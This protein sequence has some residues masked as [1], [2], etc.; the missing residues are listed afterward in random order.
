M[1]FT[2]GDRWFKDTNIF[3]TF[4]FAGISLIHRRP[5]RDGLGKC[6]FLRAAG[7]TCGAGRPESSQL[8]HSG[9]AQANAHPC[10]RSKSLADT[11]VSSRLETGADYCGLPSL[12]GGRDISAVPCSPP[13][14]CS[15]VLCWWKW[16]LRLRPFPT[17]C[18]HSVSVT[19]DAD[20]KNSSGIPLIRGIHPDCGC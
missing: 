4:A 14:G 19:W 3:Y 11:K 17:H 5:Y 16:G 20:K 8:C 13:S 6:W 2:K 7:R 10:R 9:S 18:W 15:L 12:M 1:V